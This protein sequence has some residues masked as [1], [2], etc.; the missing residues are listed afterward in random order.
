MSLASRILKAVDAA[1]THRIVAP[2]LATP[3]RAFLA[4]ELMVRKK[5]PVILAGSREHAEDIYR[6]LAFFSGVEETNAADHGILFLGSDE[7][8]PYEEYSPDAHAVMERL[9]TLHRLLKEPDT[10]RALVVTPHAMLRRHVP[11]SIFE[12]AGDYVMQGTDIDR[13]QLLARLELSGYNAVTTVEDPGTF[14]V[15][16]GI[17]DI[18]SPH[19]TRPFRLDLFGDTIDSIRLFDPETQRT[20]TEIEDAIILP[21]REIVF[22]GGTVERAQQ[23]IQ[24]LAE[25]LTIPTRVVNA[26]VD[27]IENHIHFFGIEA[28]LPIFHAEPLAACDVYLPKGDHVVYLAS[29]IEAFEAASEKVFAEARIEYEATISAHQLAIEPERHLVD[30]PETMARSLAG[31]RCVELPEIAIGTTTPTV[32]VRFE[33]TES[34]RA[35]ILRSTRA[36]EQ[37]EDVLQPL[38]DRLRAWRR[39]GLTTLIVCHTRG[40]AER[41]KQLLAP[42]NLS[43]RLH[44]RPFVLSE[45][46]GGSGSGSGS[47]G[48]GAGIDVSGDA[49]PSRLRD[50]SVHAWLVLGEIAAGFVLPEANL[51]VVAEEEI[52]GQRMKPK[53]RR[54]AAA[55]DFV[56]DLKDLKPGDY[57]VHVDF[58]IGL[59]H[60][61]TKLTVSGVESDYLLLEYKG[62]DKLYL[63]VHRLRLIQKYVTGEEG[64]QPQLDRLGT[65]TWLNTKRKIKDTLLKMAAELLRLYAMR[66]SLQ[67]FAIPPPDDTFRRFEAEFAFDPTPDQARAIEDVLKDLQRSSPMDR[68]ICGD[69]GYGKTEVAIRAAVAMALA[70]K[71]VA[72][73]VPTTVLAAQ[74]YQVF[75]ERVA[76]YPVSV[77]IVSRFQD[78]DEIKEALTAL[79][80]GKLDI[81]IGTHRILSKDVNFRDLGL[82]VIDEEHRF[83]V[84]H[85]EKLKKYRATVHVLSMSATPIPR[86]LNMGLIGVRDLSMIT[87]PPEDRLAVKT[88]VHKF[89]E[90]T[91]RESILKEIRRGGQCFVV[92]NRVSSIGAFKRMLERLVP[93]ARIGVGHGQMGEEDLEQVMVDF[94]TKKTNVLLSTTIIESGVDI[95]NANTIIINRADRFGLAQLY[96]LRGRVGRAKARGFAHFLIP[97][98]NL[99]KQAR[100]RIAVLQRFTELGAGFQVASHDLEIRGAGNIIG[101]QQSGSIAQVGFELYQTLLAEAIDELKGSER[102]SMKE[103]ELE[104]PLPSLIPDK[105]IAAPGERLSYYQRLNAADTDEAIYDLLQEM[106]DLYGTPPAEVE[107]LIELM[108][109]KQRLGR[110]S[111]LGLQYGPATKSMPPRVVLRFDQDDPNLNGAHVVQFVEQNKHRRRLTPDGRLVVHLV[112]A[113][114]LR[115]MLH[116][117]M[118]QVEQLLRVRY[119]S[120]ANNA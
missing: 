74:H 41:I 97:A 96:Q 23:Q 107:N 47:G 100:R 68:L 118:E 32:D 84:T 26:I 61:L 102:R 89:S 98:G 51:A 62:N 108:R 111:V 57:V 82:L 99:S 38:V 11:P 75:K 37:P 44:G 5:L 93:E 85:K 87:T 21:A 43:V 46:L 13:D 117:A 48:G 64:R 78:K 88:E 69:V 14:S 91:I 8:S 40:Q 105:Y 7:K 112:P 80:E 4:A 67:G 70:K 27:D 114:D 30:G 29:D 20:S 106:S 119:R 39:D 73:L 12:R 92:H 76:N 83:G 19:R 77:G 110:A 113:E 94:M 34:I 101:K 104:F 50:R 9:A 120:A 53:R 3:I 10:V 24:A 59:Y 42:K 15:R 45:L 72:V 86:T 71:Q 1:S 33:T 115:E 81:I 95:P 60:G 90:E 58:G 56:S 2:G 66:A 17:I 6:E 103:P 65:Q 28:L 49:S 36:I 54:T 18:F 16:G 22:D 31:Q 63:P 55:K 35:D 116:Q 52:F 109:L 79:K 25:E